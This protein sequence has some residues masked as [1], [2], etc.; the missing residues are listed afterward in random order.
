MAALRERLT[1]SDV[2]T[3]AF[4]DFAVSA[5][6]GLDGVNRALVHCGL[7]PPFTFA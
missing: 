1:P 3:G 6:F 5:M 2:F 4:R 7:L